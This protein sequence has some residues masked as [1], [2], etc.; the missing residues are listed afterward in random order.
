MGAFGRAALRHRRCSP[1]RARPAARGLLTAGVMADLAVL[2]LTYNEEI[3][4][5]RALRSVASIAR[6]VVVV[7]A[8][9]TDQTVAIAKRCGARVIT[10]ARQDAGGFVSLARQ[11]Q[12]GLDNA[13]FT[14]GWILKLDADEVVEADLA[15]EI[16][17]R[18][19]TLPSVVVGVN[20][21]RKHIFM[22]RW[23]RH[24]GRYPLIVMR[25]WRNGA[26]RAEDRW[27]DEHIVLSQGEIVTFDGNFADINENDLSDFTAKHNKYS[28]REA[29]DVLITK[30][31]LAESDAPALSS[32]QAALK[33]ALKEKLYNR[34]PFPVAPLA[35]FLYRYVVRLGFL[36]GIEGLIY[37]ALQGGWYRFLV[38]AKV[39]ELERR[40]RGA[41]SNADR[42]AILSHVTGHHVAG[43]RAAAGSESAPLS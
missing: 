18:L 1:T 37:H 3:H 10:C 14:A 38:G 9:S 40:I 11:L 4:I 27:A 12:W 36:D 31:G 13:G 5:E 39:T 8:G 19:P 21:K 15:E 41:N 22:G 24:G 42:L 43:A 2:I 30:Y 7:D 28:T 16:E 20:L 6:E 34:T 35:Y 32:K 25:L 26:G 29:I 33:R 23:I 17:R